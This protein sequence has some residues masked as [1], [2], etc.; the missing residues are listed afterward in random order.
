MADQHERNIYLHDVALSEALDAWH[1][2][3][4]ENGLL[5]PFGREMIPLSEALH[6]VNAAPVWA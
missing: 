2:A 3:L 1:R 6:R 5:Q 4:E